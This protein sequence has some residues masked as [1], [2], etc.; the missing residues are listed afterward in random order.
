MRKEKLLELK[1]YINE[2]KTVKIEQILGES[3]FIKVNRFNCLLNNHKTIFREEIIKNNLPGS[4][5]IIL[6]ITE[7]NNTILVV[8]PRVFTEKTVGIGL[9]AGYIEK[10]EQPLVAAARE[11]EEETGYV[12]NNLIELTKFY[13]DEGCSKAYN[14]S[15]MALNAKKLKKQH[16]DESEFIRYF[17]CTFDE[18]LELVDLGYIEGVNSILTLEKAKKYVKG[19]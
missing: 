2:L 3:Q 13:Q 5:V 7:E 18:A 1:Q 12:S 10:G 14:I 16:L 19:R 8:E 15:F 4:A 6:P 17:E 9:P 11:L